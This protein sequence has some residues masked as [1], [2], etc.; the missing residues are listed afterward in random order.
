MDIDL[1]KERFDS[2][3]EELVQNNIPLETEQDARLHII[4]RILI[5]VL[6]WERQGIKTE[7][8]TESGYVDYLLSV[9]GRA[10]LVVEA[11]RISKLL[12]D[13]RQSRM[14]WYKVSGPAIQ[15]ANEGLEQAKRYCADTA[16]FF[17]ALTTGLE[18]I[19]FW[20]VRTDGVPPREGKAV[21]FPNLESIKQNFALFYDLF[22]PEGV[23]ENL[24]QVHIHEAEGL[25]V[26]QSEILDT[27]IDPS[28]RRLLHKSPLLRDLEGV[29][30]SFFSTISGEDPDML[31]ECFVESKE[32]RAADESLEKITRNL[33]NRIDIVNSERGEEL[34]EQIR[35]AIE[36]EKGDFILIIGNKGAGKSTFIDRFFRL[37]LDK[38]LSELCLI[39]RIDLADSDGNESTISTWLIDQ[40]KNELE[41]KLF[42]DS[43]PT[44]NDLQG[45]FISEYRRWSSGQYKPLYERD[46]NA[47]KE[48]FGELINE[49]MT[50][51]PRD[52]V[53]KLLKHSISSR[54]LMPCI[55]FDNTDHFPQSFQ[56]SVFQFAQSIYRECFS[57]IICPI[58]DRTVW[59]LS[60][61]GPLQ[62]YD[63]RDFYLPVPSTKEVLTK[64]VEFIK[65]KIQE[66]SGN[67]GD[68]F[69]KRGIRLSIPDV[70]AFA[71]S[72]EGIFVNEDYVGR[73]VGWLAN[74]DIRRGLQ[75]AQRI[76]ISP[77][78]DISVLIKAY[79]I[80]E[81]FR[82][83]YRNIKKA[84]LLGE[85]NYFS[86]QESSFILNLFEIDSNSIT[87]PLLRLSILRL[88]MDVY[89]DTASDTEKIYLSADD[90]LNYFEPATV[91]RTIV[92]EH[93]KSLLDRRLIEPY[94]PTDI[95]IYES[96]RFKVTHCGR[97]HYEFVTE[98]KS[99]TYMGEMALV[100]PV[101]SH[102]YASKIRQVLE[103]NDKLSD[104]DLQK[105][106]NE[107]KIVRFFV[108]YCLEQDKLHISLPKS[109][110]YRSQEI[111]RE[112]LFRNWIES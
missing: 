99:G 56:E 58:T 11:K 29:Y 42:D 46:K 102:E 4:D 17:S 27:V 105:N 49:L 73:M 110:A 26:N 38:K 96:Q 22:S 82:P 18:W 112:V 48:K 40:L 7:P 33:L 64:R 37:I 103:E 91:S 5:E 111:L 43:F 52:Y 51:K 63:H 25:H 8:H 94:D 79:T 106:I 83:G 66:N 1:A 14:S 39:L 59:Q 107:Q 34:E 35:S 41:A 75:I 68:Y 60:K 32:S 86:Q 88:L 36:I 84:L 55:V 57:F 67:S 108:E 28:E 3:H 50:Q 23:M 45:V 72:V 76:V 65:A 53:T 31:A 93:L 10:R 69:T 6:G 109:T 101:V 61:S 104:Q 62:S 95:N 97:I 74:F 80:G 71:L 90:I 24:Y 92:K 87:S 44:Y 89:S 15:S 100:T 54:K 13:T 85:Y 98:D 77:I 47:F 16:V 2:L 12:I 21:V 70:K 78:V 20:A 19:G 9:S 81:S 30:R